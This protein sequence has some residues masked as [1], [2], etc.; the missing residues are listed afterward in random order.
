MPEASL[1]GM[2][3]DVGAKFT[4][5]LAEVKSGMVWEK[6]EMKQLWVLSSSATSGFVSDR[7]NISI[8]S[9]IAESNLPE[10]S[11]PYCVWM[12]IISF[13]GAFLFFSLFFPYL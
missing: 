4:L 9:R 3:A 7:E 6:G 2:P 11:K 10:C 12:L 1:N 13:F 5:N 8:C